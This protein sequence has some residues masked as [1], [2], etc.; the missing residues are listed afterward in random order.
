MFLTSPSIVLYKISS[1]KLSL[2]NR[3]C[4]S[5]ETRGECPPVVWGPW[6]V[7]DGAFVAAAVISLCRRQTVGAWG[8]WCALVALFD[9]FSSPGS[10]AP[11]RSLPVSEFL[12]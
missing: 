11:L 5:V 7:S 10:A 1:N 8:T 4:L 9:L 3:C 2:R 12:S 6:D